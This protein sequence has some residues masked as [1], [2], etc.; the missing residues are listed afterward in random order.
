MAATTVTNI[1]EALRYTESEEQLMLCLNEESVAWD[2]L[3][4]SGKRFIRLGG[5]GMNIESII[6]QLPQRVSGITEGGSLPSA[7]AMDTEEALFTAQPVVGMWETTWSAIMRGRRSR[8]AFKQTVALHQDG[9]RT[10]FALEMSAELLD[11]GRGRKAILSA[12]TNST[13]QDALSGMPSVLRGMILDCMDDT[14]DDTK[15]EDSASVTAVDESVPQ[16]TVSAAPAGTAAGDYWC[17]E[18]TTD[19][20]LND[21]LHLVGL[22]AIVSNADPDAVVGDYAGIDR[23]AAGGEFWE[24]PVLGNS[25]VNRSLTADLMLQ[26]K[27]V[28]RR[29]G[30][31]ASKKS[32]KGLAFLM[33]D[34]IERRYVE[35][36]DAIR[37]ADTGSGAYSGDVGPKDTYTAKGESNFTFSGIP[38]HV[39]VYS[40]ANTV[41]MLD[42]PTFGIGYVDAKVPRPIDEIFDGQV[43]FFRQTSS[44]TFEKAWYWEGQLICT[45]PRSSCRID[46]VAES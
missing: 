31:G 18:D 13:T 33:N 24:S 32:Q 7:I 4:D 11:D 37:I 14:D 39:D 40:P 36:Y 9:M 28:R 2:L 19:D 12:A 26:A 41:F 10:A 23:T 42:L 45:K 8:D 3:G 17:R 1:V 44:A 15:L 46:D 30:G 34:A 27:H 5:R 29:T 6:T 43:P 22:L 25:S 35:L 21:A 16:F 20:S 38:I